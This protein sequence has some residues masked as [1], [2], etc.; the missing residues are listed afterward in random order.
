MVSQILKVYG[1]E[2]DIVTFTKELQVTKITCSDKMV[3]LNAEF[4][5][6]D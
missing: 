3:P 6:L 1:P 4:L 2:K 5:L